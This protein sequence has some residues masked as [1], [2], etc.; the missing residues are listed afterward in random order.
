MGIGDV[1]SLLDGRLYSHDWQKAAFTGQGSGFYHSPLY[2]AGLPGAGSVPSAGV[3]GTAVANARTGTILAPAAVASKSCELH[4]ADFSAAANIGSA[5]LIDRMWEN[6]GLSVTSTSSQAITPAALP[7]RSADGTANGLGVFF[8]IEVTASLG[9]ATATATLTYT[10]SD[11]TAG[12]TATLTV[13]TSCVAGTLLIFPWAAGG[14][15]VRVPTAF[16]LSASLL[17]GS[18]SLVGGRR[19]GR[20]LRAVNAH[21][22]DAFGPADGGHPIPDG[23][24]PQFVYLLTGTAAGASDGTVQFTQA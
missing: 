19:L 6:S 4:L 1:D 2:V 12:K 5:F 18:L 23:C 24:A 16:Q 15:G 9:A 20:K 17:S 21:S 11:G 8:A 3:N 7:L 10:D 13:P 14:Y 22:P